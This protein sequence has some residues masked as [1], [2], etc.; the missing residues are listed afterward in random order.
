MKN[1]TAKQIAKQLNLSEAAVSMALHNKPG[2]STGTRRRIIDTA[3]SLGY[4]FS[5]IMPNASEKSGC[6][7]IVFYNK[8]NI[9]QKSFFPPLLNGIEAEL[10]TQGYKTVLNHFHDIDDI[11]EQIGNLTSLG[12]DGIILLGTEMIREDFAP[13][14]FLKCPIVLVDTYYQ[15]VK[16]DCVVINNVDGAMLATNYLIKKR[17]TYPGY[18]RSST[19]INNFSE[20]ADGFY[21]AVRQNGFSPSKCIVHTLSPSIEGTYADMLEII[22]SGEELA[23][24][25]FADYDEIA[26]GA[27]RAFKARGY[28]IPEDISIIGFDN[29]ELSSYIDPPLTTVNVPNEYMGKLAAQRMITVLKEKEY[30]AIKIEVNTNLIVRK[31]VVAKY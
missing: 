15:S 5:K 21:K 18:L 1:I 11:E 14:A 9:F 30:H 19:R 27:M 28:K 22:D 23:D 16:M 13:F 31:S 17:H 8:T 29:S 4:D 7:A 25:Y 12:C 26:I 3:K 6:I 10:K 24:C 20:R 2:V